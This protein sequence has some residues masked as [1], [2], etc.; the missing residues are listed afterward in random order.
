MRAKIGTLTT[1]TAKTICGNP[2]PSQ[3]TIPMASRIPGIASMTSTTRIRTE[4]T[5]PPM[6]PAAAPI[7]PPMKTPMTTEAMPATRLTWAPYRMRLYSS[8]PWRSVPMM[9][10]REGVSS[11]SDSLPSCGPKGARNGAKSAAPTNTAM[12]TMPRIAGRLRSRRRKASRHSPRL[13]RASLGAVIV[14]A[15]AAIRRT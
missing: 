1:A 8:R 11:R 12:K 10:S 4:S 6:P 15:G 7:A 3:A 9:C 5:R 2:R 13:A 14:V